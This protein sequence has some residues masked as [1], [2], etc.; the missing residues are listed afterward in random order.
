MLNLSYVL[1]NDFT[2][3][4]DRGT[5]CPGLPRIICLFKL[6]EPPPG[7]LLSPRQSRS[8]DVCTTTS[9]NWNI[10]VDKK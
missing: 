6:K 4:I 7:E 9:N 5:N 10:I 3:K 2:V 1:R 8:I